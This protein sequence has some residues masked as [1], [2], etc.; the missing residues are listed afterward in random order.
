LV[1]AVCIQNVESF[2]RERNQNPIPLEYPLP[3]PMTVDMVLEESIFRRKSVRNFTQQLVTDEELSTILWAAYGLRDDGERT[4]PGIDSL[5]GSIIYV[6]KE[7][8][9]YTYDS[10]NHSLVFYKDG[11][12]RDIVGYQYWAP[13]QLALCYNTD[14][15]DPCSGG[16]EIGQIGQ[17]IEFIVNALEMGTL[18]TAQIPPA[19]DPMGLPGNEVGLTVMPIGHPDYDSYKFT[20]R[21][22]W[23]S[24]LPKIKKS[25]ISLTT[26]F[27][28]RNEEETFSGS[29]SRQDQ[30]QILWATCGYSYYRDKSDDPIYHK[31]RHRT[32]PSGKGYYPI[33][34]FM[35][36]KK[37]ISKYVPNA[38]QLYTVP[39]D[40]HGLPIVTGMLPII[41]GDYR[42]EIAMACSQSA[43]A[44]AEFSIIAVLDREKTRPPDLPDLSSDLFLPT[45]YH[46]A[47]AAA[48]NVLLEAEA[49]DLSANR[50]SVVGQNSIC[51]LLELNESTN[52]PIYVI[53]LGKLKE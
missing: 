35:V 48:Q 25:E 29:L 18:V 1:L 32:I 36:T 28:Q 38:I 5:H 45:W 30:S 2:Q 14:I 40:F 31:G 47:G 41:K 20:Y 15:L 22:L 39:V 27:K 43:I 24:F 26:A 52:I 4:V 10:I 11:N 23:I 17:N 50:Y 49:W 3:P 6:L 33:Q 19:T 21:P 7:E 9:A 12:W 51:S 34:F 44:S 37:G 16:E 42:D 46:D 13:I 53:P 8:A